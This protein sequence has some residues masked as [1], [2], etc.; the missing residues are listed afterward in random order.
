[1]IEPFW[2]SRFRQVGPPEGALP[3]LW[4]IWSEATET[5]IQKY[6][7]DHPKLVAEAKRAGISQGEMLALIAHDIYIQ[8]RRELVERWRGE[9]PEEPEEPEESD[10]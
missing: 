5:V 8:E 9:E 7:I 6:P 10:D 2:S 1:M 3:E 4:A